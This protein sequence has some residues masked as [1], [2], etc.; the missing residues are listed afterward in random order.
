MV[1]N[2]QVYRVVEDKDGKKIERIVSPISS[3]YPPGGREIVTYILLAPVYVLGAI[4][5]M[6]VIVAST[7]MQPNGLGGLPF[8]K[9]PKMLIT[10]IVRDEHGRIVEVVERVV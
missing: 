5:L 10:E 3:L 8:Q 2:N 9:Q 4:L 7:L 1:D 6:P